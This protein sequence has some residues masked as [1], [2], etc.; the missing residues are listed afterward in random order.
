MRSGRSKITSKLKVLT[1]DIQLLCT[2][3]TMQRVDP[4]ISL[5]SVLSCIIL[6]EW[7]NLKSVM[8]LDSAY[9]CHSHRNE[10]L[11]LL[12]SNE[13]FIREKVTIS[14]RKTV[15]HFPIRL[16]LFQR[17][18]EKFRSVEFSGAELVPEH[19]ALIH[20][21]CHNLTHIMIYGDEDSFTPE[22]WSL[23]K[24]NPNIEALGLD[25]ENWVE[26]AIPLLLSLSDI[27]LLKLNT[28]AVV[29]C[30][31]EDD[32]ILTVIKARNIVRL[33]LPYCEFASNI[34]I[35]IVDLCP[36]L[37]SICLMSCWPVTNEDLSAFATMCP[38][39]VHMD[40][41]N[42]QGMTDDGILSI[43]LNLKGLQFLNIENVVHV[44]DLSLVHIY[45]H[46]ASTLHTLYLDYSFGTETPFSGDAVNILME[47]CTQL[48]LISV[49]GRCTTP[50]VL[51]P[52]AIRNISTFYFY[53]QPA[54]EQNLA[55]IGANGDCIEEL[56]VFGDYAYTHDSLLNLVNGC[57]NLKQL[58]VQHRP[59]TNIPEYLKT[60]YWSEIRPNLRIR[61]F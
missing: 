28:L 48:Q 20:A 43:V 5:P 27:D 33:D 45:T 10:F 54:M 59:Y 4:L 23:L 35:R 50:L 57:P 1:S 7:L 40:I 30:I 41:S 17:F 19:S 58:M 38:F 15:R 39:I 29:S 60:A 8:A 52:A 56:A 16:N 25:T 3:L 55:T 36:R 49:I 47:R 18:G 24:N 13:Y 9:C 2:S 37:S 53:G 11:G 6:Q 14:N 44:T 34:L 31:F 21:N 12:Q 42:A 32:N 51:S 26:S 22:L 46:C 61:V